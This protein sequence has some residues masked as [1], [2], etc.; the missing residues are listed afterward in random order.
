MPN[1]QIMSAKDFLQ[2]LLKYG[3]IHIGTKGSHFKIENPKNGK[4]TSV[5]VH[6]NRDIDRA[7]TK[8][9]LTRLGI[10]T[11]DFLYFIRKHNQL[12]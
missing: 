9:I 11:D 6:G 2:W 5:P 8:A 1:I 4:R 12:S 3:C 10:D 7:F